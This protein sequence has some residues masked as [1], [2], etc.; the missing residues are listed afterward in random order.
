[1]PMSPRSAAHSPNWPGR[2]ACPGATCGPSCSTSPRTWPRP[3]R[4]DG[5]LPEV[6]ILDEVW[7]AARRQRRLVDVLVHPPRPPRIRPRTNRPGA[8]VD[9]LF[10]AAA[11]AW[12]EA[13]VDG[14]TTGHRSAPRF[15]NTSHARPDR[16][17]GLGPP[18]ADVATFLDF[19]R[20]DEDR[21]TEVDASWRVAHLGV[22][23]VAVAPGLARM[24]LAARPSQIPVRIDLPIVL[25]WPLVWVVWAILTRGVGCSGVSGSSRRGSTAGR[26]A[27]AVRPSSGPGAPATT[28]LVTAA[29]IRDGAAGP[30]WLAWINWVAAL[31]VVV[32]AVLLALGSP[33]RLPHDRVAGIWLVPS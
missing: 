3:S 8:G 19:L 1:M 21:P 33:W 29:V 10:H 12:R 7:I 22:Q 11:P 15:P 16:L 23:A 18:Y 28:F 9:L 6:L 14:T 4:L 31:L 13:G 17:N 20:A 27:V 5:T 26:P 2:R 24:F 32:A 30:A 25:A